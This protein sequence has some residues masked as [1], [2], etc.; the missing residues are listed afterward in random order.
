MKRS[1]LRGVSFN[2]KRCCGSDKARR[3]RLLVPSLGHRAFHR[4]MSRYMSFI[5]TGAVVVAGIIA[6]AWMFQRTL[7]YFPFGHVPGPPDVGLTR[8]EVVTFPTADGLTLRGWFVPAQGRRPRIRC[9]FSTAMLAIGRTV[10]RSQYRSSSMGFRYFCSTIAG[11]AAT[12][13]SQPRPV[14]E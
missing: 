5:L 8:A 12:R 6:L 3:D 7:I 10:R 14:S 9:W 4:R 13:G 1:G 11:T 2:R